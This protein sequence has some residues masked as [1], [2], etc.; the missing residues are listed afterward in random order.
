MAQKSLS[1]ST[2]D[3]EECE[4]KVADMAVEGQDFARVEDVGKRGSKKSMG[5]KNRARV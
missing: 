3:K 2:E 5:L 1:F 4:A